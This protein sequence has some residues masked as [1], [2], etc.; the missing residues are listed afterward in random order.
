EFLKP[1]GLIFQAHVR[2]LSAMIAFFLSLYARISTVLVSY[3]L[4]GIVE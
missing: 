1:A 2:Y 3:G 4:Q